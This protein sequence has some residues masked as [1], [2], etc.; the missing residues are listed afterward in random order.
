MEEH[1]VSKAKA[2][3]WTFCRLF[4]FSCFSN[5]SSIYKISLVY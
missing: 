1:T 5:I 2:F 3:Q 4:Y